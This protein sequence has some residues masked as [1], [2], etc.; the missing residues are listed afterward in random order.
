METLQNLNSQRPAIQYKIGLKFIHYFGRHE[1]A[2]YIAL[3]CLGDSRH[4][5]LNLRPLVPQEDITQI[6]FRVTQPCMQCLKL[7]HGR[8][9]HLFIIKN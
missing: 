9:L 7:P 5:L 8:Y 6:F 1:M 3:F 2:T 4:C